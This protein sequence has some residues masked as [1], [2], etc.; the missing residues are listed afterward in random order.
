ME[1]RCASMPVSSPLDDSVAETRG[2][3]EDP[4]R[5]LE[6]VPL[7]ADLPASELQDLVRVMQPIERPANAPLWRQGEAA[8][9]LHVIVEGK[10]AI[11]L[12]QPGGA[13]LRVATLGPRDVVGEVPLLDGGTRSAS[14]HVESAARLL[15]LSRADFEALTLR[16]HPTALAVRRR[17]LLLVCERLR[18]AYRELAVT[19][20]GE[21]EGPRSEPPGSGEMTR[22]SPPTD[23]LRRL[24]MFRGF[25][26]A[27]LLELLDRSELALVGR[28]HIL[29]AEGDPARALM[30]TLNG[31]V[32]EA[33]ERGNQRIPVGLAGPGRAFSYIGLIDLGPSALIARARERSLVLVVPGPVFQEYFHGTD[34]TSYALFAGVERDL[35]T[36]LRRKDV[37]FVRAARA[38]RALKLSPERPWSPNRRLG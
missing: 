13:E 11:S 15:F 3:T 38:P 14:A 32:E 5:A 34:P 6:S 23:Y 22:T 20:D 17:I 24:A 8:D 37:G 30:V 21:L 18:K 33:I 10:I 25:G 29:A 16:R 9:G 28:G 2:L 35:I 31:A 7:F 27:E 4:L 19:L 26:A 12:R 1:S 36:A